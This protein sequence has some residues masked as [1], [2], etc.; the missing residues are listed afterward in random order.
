MKQVTLGK[1][2]ITVPQNG[3]GALPIQRVTLSE[4]V[5]ILRN[6]YAGGMRFFDTARAYSDSEEKLGAAFGD[7]YVRREEIIIAT[8]TPAKTPEDF[9]KDLETSLDKL[10]TDYIDIYQFHLMGECWKPGEANGMYDCML[11]AKEQGKIRHIGGTAHKLGVAREIVTSGF[12]ETLQYPISYLAD[13]KEIELMRLTAEHDMGL[14]CMKGMAGGLISNAKAAMAFINQY[15][16]AVPIWGIQRQSE[17]TEWL[18]FMEE[19]P[20]MDEETAAFIRKEQEELKGEFCRGCGYCMPCTVGIQIN[21]CNRMS[22]MLR[23][24]PSKDWLSEY[25]QGEM[26]KVDDCIGCGACLS[27][28]PYE[29]DIPRL[30]KKNLADYR[31]VLAGNRSVS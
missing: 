26:A 18:S 27:K 7:G 20:V 6:A 3:F 12:Y 23:R 13:D 2:G 4:A 14:I 1:T 31:E 22:L 19:T 29:L 11:K 16:N 8:K 24:A 9:W 17:L 28:C 15:D 5:P 10:K 30:L 21:Q 25:W